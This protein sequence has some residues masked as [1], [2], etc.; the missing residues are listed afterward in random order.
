MEGSFANTDFNIELDFAKRALRND[1]NSLF[2][3]Q[4][5]ITK[6]TKIASKISA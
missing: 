2:N 5:E 4:W 3:M 6:S 1:K